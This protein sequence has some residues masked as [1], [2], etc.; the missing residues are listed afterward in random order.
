MRPPQANRQFTPPKDNAKQIQRMKKS[1][2]QK[3]PH[4]PAK[5]KP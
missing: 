2:L 4:K 1:D 3:P 5:T